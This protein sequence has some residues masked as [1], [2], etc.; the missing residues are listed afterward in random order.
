IICVSTWI[1]CR[2]VMS[3]PQIGQADGVAA[4]VVAATAGIWDLPLT[5]CETLRSGL[6][7]ASS[8]LVEPGRVDDLAPLH[9]H[10]HVPRARRGHGRADDEALVG[11]EHRR[12]LPGEVRPPEHLG[13]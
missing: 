2:S 4:L 10:A 9:Q 5:D 3:K 13:R 7:L 1:T 6:M 12:P 8:P 11:H